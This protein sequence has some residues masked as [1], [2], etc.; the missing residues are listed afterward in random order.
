MEN[1]EWR[2]SALTANRLIVELD[3]GRTEDPVR[4]VR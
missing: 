1:V 2:L 4:Q 3:C